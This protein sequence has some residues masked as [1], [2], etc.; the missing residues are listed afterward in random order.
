MAAAGYASPARYAMP[1]AACASVLAGVAVAALAGRVLAFAPPSG[2]ARRALASP[3]AAV[4]PRRAA[5]T[6][7]A[8]LAAVAFAVPAAGRLARLDDQVRDGTA[9]ARSNEQLRAAIGA[10]GGA[11]ALRRCA[12][13]GWVAVNHTAQSA[14]AWELRSGLG[15]V[16]LTMRRPGLLVRAPRSAATGAPPRMALRGRLRGVE[17]ARA[18]AWSVLAVRAADA[19]FPPACGG[20]KA[21]GPARRIPNI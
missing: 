10:A 6:A 12:L 4:R 13:Q 2:A 16:A 18:G 1:A 9:V 7:L 14:L 20:R 3:L 19:P 15:H 21:S 11:D 5:W 8:L 17:L